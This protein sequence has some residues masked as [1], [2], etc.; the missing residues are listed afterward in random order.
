M[1]YLNFVFVW[2]ANA[3]QVPHDEHKE[4]GESNVRNAGS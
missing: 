2:N 4:R 1:I 3:T